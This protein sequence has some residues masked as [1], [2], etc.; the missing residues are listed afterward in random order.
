MELHVWK[1]VWCGNMVEEVKEVEELERLTLGRTCQHDRQS[2]RVGAG[3]GEVCGY[4]GGGHL[5]LASLMRVRSDRAV[6]GA[7]ILP[8]PP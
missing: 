5:T 2:W 6:G 8:R 7:I 1:R 3:S 4:G